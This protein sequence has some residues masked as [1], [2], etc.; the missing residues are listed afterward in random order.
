MADNK[1]EYLSGR[2][3]LT[4]GDI[5]A[6]NTDAIVNAANSSLLG[7][8]GVD[9]AIH[10]GAGKGLLAECRTLG[11]CNTGEAKITSGYNLPAKMIIHTVGPV[12]KGGEK[13]E[14]ALL[15]NCYLNSLSLASERSLESIAFPSISTGVF[16]YPINKAA[17]TALDTVRA[18]LELNPKPEKVF[19]VTYSNKDFDVYESVAMKLGI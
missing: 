6:F 17:E 5:T 12:W 8:G 10:R 16:G 1:R 15:R 3:V 14:E 18:F 13:G 9:G 7:G 19:F 11:G 2:I 4:V